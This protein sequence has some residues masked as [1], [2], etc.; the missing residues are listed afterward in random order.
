MKV[1]YVLVDIDH[2]LSN[3]AWRDNM[4]GVASWDEYHSAAINDNPIH[5]IA[6]L[7]KSLHNRYTV[8]GFTARPEKFRGM[9]SRWCF[10]HEIPLDEL[11]MR[12]YDN[13]EKAPETKLNL[14]K[15]RFGQSVDQIAFALEDRDDCCVALR[16]L[17][18][19]VLQVYARIK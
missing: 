1:K 3:A 7:V 2:T 4:I 12:D 10:L 19:T 6:E 11:L 17:G 9:T 16:G 15:K 13:Y 18:I 5:D 8:I 14:I